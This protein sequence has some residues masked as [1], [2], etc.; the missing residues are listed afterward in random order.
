M[1]MLKDYFLVK[2]NNIMLNE[3]VKDYFLTDKNNI[4]TNG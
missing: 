4:L 3:R 1:C 2:R